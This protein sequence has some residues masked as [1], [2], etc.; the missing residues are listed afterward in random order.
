MPKNKRSQKK[1]FRPLYIQPFATNS[2]VLILPKRLSLCKRV[3][4]LNGQKGFQAFYSFHRSDR[5]STPGND[6]IS[7][8][9]SRHEINLK[10]SEKIYAFFNQSQLHRTTKYTHKKK[11]IN[12]SQIKMQLSM[13][14]KLSL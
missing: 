3:I 13:R 12:P 5:V 1:D 4:A 7:H 6:P 11:P 9:N 14:I 8:E 2:R 10:S